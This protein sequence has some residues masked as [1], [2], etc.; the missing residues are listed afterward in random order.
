MN[1]LGAVMESRGV[2]IER[3]CDVCDR[4]NWSRTTLWRRVKAGDFPR[5]LRLG[6]NSVGWR[7]DEVD[8]WISAR[9]RA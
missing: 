3:A 9:D 1:A 7:S 8:Q 6:P 5:P 2:R 4:V